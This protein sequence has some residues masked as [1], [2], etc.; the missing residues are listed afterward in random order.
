MTYGQVKPRVSFSVVIGLKGYRL[1]NIFMIIGKNK[2][3][4]E[5]LYGAA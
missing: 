1:D 5:M 2:G 3:V 4:V